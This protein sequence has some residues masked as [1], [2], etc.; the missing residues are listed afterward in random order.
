MKV[1][2]DFA[3]RVAILKFLDYRR[4][5]VTDV[6]DLRQLTPRAVV[7]Q[8]RELAADRFQWPLAVGFVLLLVAPWVSD[9]TARA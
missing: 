5:P 3:I 9:R 8:A 7:G 6:V 4:Q 1:G 2:N